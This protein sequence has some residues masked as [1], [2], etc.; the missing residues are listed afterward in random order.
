L[1]L[2]D[3]LLN[4][5]IDV[6]SFWYTWIKVLEFVNNDNGIVIV[7]GKRDKDVLS[8]LLLEKNVVAIQS[9]PVYELERL[10]EHISNILILTDFDKEGE[11]LANRL[12][13]ELSNMGLKI[14]THL[15]E[16]VKEA[17]KPIRQIEALNHF[18]EELLEKAPLKVIL[19][20]L[21]V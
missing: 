2:G 9:L 10:F 5:K 20:E 13:F 7:E 18:L 12:Y 14:N 6:E 4:R 11:S 3:I 8:R 19:T 16:K 15:R 21:K 1:S 17:I